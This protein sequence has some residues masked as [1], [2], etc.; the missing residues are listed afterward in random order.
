[1]LASTLWGSLLRFL[2]LGLF[3][4]V[5]AFVI[6]AGLNIVLA[7]AGSPGRCTPGGGTVS[8]GALNATS[9][10][11]KWDQYDQTLDAGSPASVTFTE[12]EISSRAEQY[13]EENNAPVKDV[14]V[15][16]HAGFGEAS[17][18]LDTP[19]GIDADVRV[20]G[21]MDLTGPHPKANIDD[22]EVGGVPGFLIDPVKGYLEDLIA[23]QLDDIDLNHSHN[24]TI[25]EG[26]ADL[27]GTP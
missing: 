14:L 4:L 15:C 20:K 23:N 8:I 22:V 17:G 9:F 19:L 6:V 24:A 2:V 21:S 12:S 26:S 25:N 10:Q 1:M 27:Q 16:M 13:L 5:G 7:F 11:S 18:S 3:L